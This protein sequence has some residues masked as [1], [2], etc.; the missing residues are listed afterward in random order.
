MIQDDSYAPPLRV[1][2]FIATKRG[3][4]ERGPMVMM[5]ADEARIRMLTDGE[6]A[7]VHGPRRHDLAELRVDERLRRGEAVL[8]DIAGA[9]PTEVITVVKPDL[10]S[11]K[12][13]NLA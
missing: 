4:A 1:V 12:P 5:N 9:A 3:D 7:W 10:D 11:N 8:R 6:L 2:A 13:N